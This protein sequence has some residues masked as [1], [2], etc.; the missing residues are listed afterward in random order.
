MNRFRLWFSRNGFKI[1]LMIVGILI[2]YI[3]IKGWN[4]YYRNE[5]ES[6]Q[7]EVLGETNELNQSNEMNL[8]NSNFVEIKNTSTEYEKINS[9]V[10]KM[11]TYVSR[12]VLNSDNVSTIQDIRN[13]FTN[14]YIE[15]LSNL[16][17]YMLRVDCILNFIYDAENIDQYSVGNVYRFYKN[18]EV[19]RYLVELK[20]NKSDDEFTTIYLI[21]NMDYKN[22]TFS[23][24]GT[25]ID[26]QDITFDK[27][28]DSIENK[29]SNT[30]E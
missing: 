24:D 1:F 13:M 4:N 12:A 9:V 5:L 2:L 15:K 28:I 17:E 18:K 25:V 20:Y 29:G 10:Q 3:F 21:I 8:D 16:A 7:Q 27:K 26:E 22:N 30:F 23:Y 6:E 11:L 19:E 14:E